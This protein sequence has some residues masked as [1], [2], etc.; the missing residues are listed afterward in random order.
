[1]A[2]LGNLRRDFSAE[3]TRGAAGVEV[4]CELSRVE[5]GFCD[6]QALTAS[7]GSPHSNAALWSE[8]YTTNDAVRQALYPNTSTTAPSRCADS[9]RLK[10]FVD[11]GQ[12]TSTRDRSIL[13]TSAQAEYLGQNFYGAA[14]RQT[15]SSADLNASQ[16]L[17]PHRAVHAETRCWPPR[18]ANL[19]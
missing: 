7:V 3:L 19:H 9:K 16:L 5:G 2:F 13:L 4:S 10:A 14:E 8:F 11:I 12:L 6:L 1:V 18:Y 15:S 17:L